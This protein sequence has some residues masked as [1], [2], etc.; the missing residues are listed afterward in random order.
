VPALVT[1][2]VVMFKLQR[3]TLQT[4]SQ[5]P[6]ATRSSVWRTQLDEHVRPQATCP[7]WPVTR[8]APDS[9]ALVSWR[10]LT[11]QMHMLSDCNIIIRG[12]ATELAPM[13]PYTRPRQARQEGTAGPFYVG[14]ASRGRMTGQGP[15]AHPHMHAHAKAAHRAVP[16]P[17]ARQS[18]PPLWYSQVAATAASMPGW[19][20]LLGA[21]DRQHAAASCVGAICSGRVVLRSEAGSN[22]HHRGSAAVF[23]PA[24]Q[25]TAPFGAV[26]DAM[27]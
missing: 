8:I 19:N 27:W 13:R 26:A 14:V 17:A 7:Y 22:G 1:T 20:A 12:W 2:L 10:C 3:I 23:I 6:T 16:C 5:P 11:M 24:G 15:Y 25:C 21:R 4:C 9:P 18:R